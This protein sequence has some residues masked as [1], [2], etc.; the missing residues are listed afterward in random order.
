V[1]FPIKLNHPEGAPGKRITARNEA[2]FA[3]LTRI[4]WQAI[5][6][7]RTIEGGSARVAADEPAQ[8]EAEN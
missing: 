3:S 1:K 4:G 2:E 8:L 6:D 5:E 7:P